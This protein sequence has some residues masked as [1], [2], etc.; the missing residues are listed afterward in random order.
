MLPSCLL[1]NGVENR[2]HGLE[3]LQDPRGEYSWTRCDSKRDLRN[4]G[5][6]FGNNTATN[7]GRTSTGRRVRRCFK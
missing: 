4:K 6:G 2:Y 5:M 1:E 7:L 3:L